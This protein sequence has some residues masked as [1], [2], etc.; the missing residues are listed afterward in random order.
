MH[1]GVLVLADELLS[2]HFFCSIAL[3]FV[4]INNNSKWIWFLFLC[5]CY[6]ILKFL[7][8]VNELEFFKLFI[9]LLILEFV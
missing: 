9:Y 2:F 8:M 6:L 7:S 3:C 5:L 1:L 4:L